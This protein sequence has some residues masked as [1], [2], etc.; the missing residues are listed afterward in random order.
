LFADSKPRRSKKGKEL[1]P[2]HKKKTKRWVFLI[3]FVTTILLLIAFFT[4]SN[5][6]RST[7]Y[8][9]LDSAFDEKW[10]PFIAESAS[11]R[12]VIDQIFE[13]ISE[14][15]ARGELTPRAGNIT[16]EQLD[17]GSVLYTITINEGMVYSDGTP[18][19][20]DDYIWALMVRA[21]PSYAGKPGFLLHSNIEGVKE[22]FFDDPNYEAIINEIE[23]I[24]IE[25]YSS[26][27]IS[28]EDFSVYAKATNLDGRW[29]GDPTSEIISGIT[30]LDYIQDESN[31]FADRL[32]AID[33]DDADLVFELLIEIEFAYV[34][35]YPTLDWFIANM[36][37]V[38]ALENLESGIQ[39]PDISGIN[40]ID[41]YTC[42][43]LITE[44]DIYD[45]HHLTIQNGLGNLIPRHHYGE[46]VKGDVSSIVNNMDPLG[47]GHYKWEGIREDIITVKANETHWQG[48]PGTSILRWIHV[49]E[50]EVLL[51]LTSGNIDVGFFDGNRIEEI[52]SLG[53]SYHPIGTAGY[54]FMG[55]NAEN[56]D[57]NVRRGIFSLMN[58]ELTLQHFGDRTTQLIHRPM[59]P[60]LAEYPI[61]ASDMYPYSPESAF[62]YFLEAG[63]APDESGKLVDEYGNQLSLNI[64]IIA[65][66]TGNHPAYSMLIQAEEDMKTLGGELVIIDAEVHELNTARMTGMADA[67]IMAWGNVYTSDRSTQFG[68]NGSQ[69]YHRFSDNEMDSLLEEILITLDLAERRELVSHMLDLAMEQAIELP[70][71]QRID[72]IAY[73]NQKIEDVFVDLQWFLTS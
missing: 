26:E 7:L 65:S 63:F 58:R 53:I 5:D 25:K 67:W 64:Y 44:I 59:S 41:D 39:I 23:I 56:V 68:T 45:K 40:R 52:R 29:T 46:Y 28:F 30:W 62:G 72:V 20:I 9:G 71:Y 49:P 73:N 61:D 54:G 14:L 15:N 69:N 31:Y 66:G 35:S 27:T 18:I 47:S 50:A 37:S 16:F 36:K 1:S 57:I 43:I 55:M 70:L 33:P 42:T 4:L 13:P 24:A 6:I 10:N 38:R 32:A 60:T 11:N 21:D 34:L 12:Q 19:T 22:Y 48:E 2:L 3:V 51:K 8:I 17:D